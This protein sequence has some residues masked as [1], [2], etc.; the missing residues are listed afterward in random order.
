M[1]AERYSFDVNIV[2]DN[3]KKLVRTKSINKIAATIG[4]TSAGLHSA[5]KRGE[6]PLKALVST[7]IMNGWSLDQL[8][9]IDVSLELNKAF[10]HTYSHINYGKQPC[11]VRF[12]SEPHNTEVVLSYYDE[13][14]LVLDSYFGPETNAFQYFGPEVI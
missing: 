10:S 11:S 14:I 1:T 6:L 5:I 8:F 3:I 2:V 4:V 12:S 9:G 13:V 7:A